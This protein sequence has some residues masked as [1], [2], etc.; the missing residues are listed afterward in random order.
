MPWR[1][2]AGP[3]AP[4]SVADR[5]PDERLDWSAVGAG[6]PRA[7]KPWVE[8]VSQRIAEESRPEQHGED[9]HRP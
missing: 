8:S 7:A 5:K 1:S 9:V 2:C 6:S 3:P 4:A